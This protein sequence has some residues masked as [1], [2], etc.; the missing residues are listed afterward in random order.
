MINNDD[1]VKNSKAY[2]RILVNESK[3]GVRRKLQILDDTIDDYMDMIKVEIDKLDENPVYQRQM[4]QLLADTTKEHSEFLMALKRTA[5]S[6][7]SGSMV[8]PKAQP[9]AKP[10]GQNFDQED[11]GEEEQEQES[12]NEIITGKKDG[13]FILFTGNDGTTVAKALGHSVWGSIGVPVGIIKELE[14]KLKTQIDI[15]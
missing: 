9:S 10:N 14:K 8:M 11:G 5:A 1:R 3:K 6:L 13:K 2:D 7:D 12:V 4:Y 15:K